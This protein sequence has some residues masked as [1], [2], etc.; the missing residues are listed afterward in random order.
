MPLLFAILVRIDL[1][2]QRLFVNDQ[3]VSLTATEYCLL[4]E[5]V[6]QAGRI[7]ISE[8]LLE[9]VWGVGYEHEDRILRQVVYRLRKKIERDP[10]NPEYIQFTPA[11]FHSF[12]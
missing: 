9:T 12:Y 2:Q 4:I 6:K 11:M 5:L 10:K 7:V 8:H 3:E 1:A